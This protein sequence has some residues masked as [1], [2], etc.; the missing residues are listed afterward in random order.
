MLLPATLSS[1]KSFRL[2]QWFSQ[3]DALKELDFL[4]LCKAFVL[5]TKHFNR[6]EFVSRGVR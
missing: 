2:G 6:F 4:A 3:L 1:A 5:G